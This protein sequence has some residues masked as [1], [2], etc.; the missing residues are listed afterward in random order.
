MV[1]EKC[2]A[3]FLNAHRSGQKNLDRL[4]TPEAWRDNSGHSVNP[5]PPQ[6]G[7][8]KL[9]LKRP[10]AGTLT[11][12]NYVVPGCPMQRHIIAKIAHTTRESVPCVEF[13]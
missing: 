8:N 4:A 2:K 11:A 10:P 1:C 12:A 9:L 7:G 13:D 6:I 5:K 3:L